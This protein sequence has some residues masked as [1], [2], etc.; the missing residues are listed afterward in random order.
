MAS[1][2]I[3]ISGLDSNYR[4]PGAF[5]EIVYAQGPAGA[6]A[7]GREVV[8]AM[9]MLASGT[10]TAGT[11]YRID[12]AGEAETGAGAGSPLHRAAKIFRTAN[13]DA[14]L[15]GLPVAATTGGSPV[16]ATA[17]VTYATNAS[18]TGTAI[19]RVCG[20]E[21]SFTFRSGDTP[22]II[23]AGV[24]AS[25]NAKTWLPVTALNASGVLTITAKLLGL[26]Q[27]TASLGVIRVAASITAGVGTTVA[28]SGA[29]LGSTLAGADGT[30][31]EA[32]QLVTALANVANVRKYF[33]VSSAND[34]TS[35]TNLKTHVAT[36]SEPR[37]GLR[38][39][40]VFGYTG[41]LANGITLSTGRNYERLRM[42]HQIN[43]EH[44][45]AEL[46]ANLAAILQKRETT[47]SAFN[48]NGYRE[49]DWLILP[50]ASTTD[51]P[52]G[53][54]INDAINAGITL[55][56]SDDSGSY[57]AMSCSTR[58]KN[59][60]G[61]VSD[62]RVTETK[63]V[64]VT[65]EFVD[66]EIVDW[67]QTD[68]AKKFRDDE[69]LADGSVNPNQRF[70]R[71]VLTPSQREGRIKK[72]MDDFFAAGKL[73]EV[74]SSKASVRSFKTGG[75]LEVGFDLTVISWANQMTA[76]VAETTPG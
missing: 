14:R 2:R 64:S 23:A 49:F 61:T 36:K 54:D 10:W 68:S 12:N 20:E 30:T 26:S 51:W 3:P 24:M 11:L 22:T 18:A 63:Q 53:D 33:V 38:S 41:S 62:F 70:Q 37:R 59:A 45:T 5:A 40:G 27:G 50:A 1:L 39:V 43:S 13:K 19:V 31:T 75:R 71:N 73:Q 25:I 29:F 34:S 57:V 74:D 47:D 17:T 67:Y 48:F 9:P 8:L 56:G 35:I 21:C 16:A 44:D 72:R 66:E 55:I 15:W 4:T 28:T 69:R 76:R 65:D 7:P 42:A 52:S 32:A 46:A 6:A 60:S 58:S